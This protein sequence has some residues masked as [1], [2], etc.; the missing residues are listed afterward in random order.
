MTTPR[1][2]GTAEALV[3]AIADRGS[4]GTAKQL[5]E[6]TKGLK[7]Q[8]LTE[9]AICTAVVRSVLQ[10]G[11][12]I[13]AKGGSMDVA[14]ERLKDLMHTLDGAIQDDIIGPRD[15]FDMFEDAFETST[16]EFNKRIFTVL[17]ENTNLWAS[18][19][20]YARGKLP[21][22]RMCN[23]LLKRLSRS[24]DNVYSG[25][26]LTFLAHLYP[27]S[28]KSGLNL[29]GAFSEDAQL[30]TLDG[31]VD[32]GDE[33]MDAGNG[34]AGPSADQNG[35]GA[36]TGEVAAVDST[37]DA[38]GDFHRSFWDLQTYLL[39]PRKVYESEKDW[40]R[41][42]ARIEIVLEAFSTGAA[43]VASGAEVKGEDDEQMDTDAVVSGR[44][45]DGGDL[46]FPKHLTSGS[47]MTMQLKDT[48][49]RR[50]ICVQLLIAFQYL[51]ANVKFKTPEQ[52]LKPQQENF[53]DACIPKV[54]DV[55][56]KTPPDGKRFLR[57]IKYLLANEEFWS[58][59]KN[60]GCP[61]FEREPVTVDASVY[62]KGQEPIWESLA[63][64]MG[65]EDPDKSIDMGDPEL[66]R[67]WN[68]QVDLKDPTRG[69]VPNSSEIFEELVEQEDPDA[70]I[71]E[72]YLVIK[73]PMVRFRALRLLLRNRL[74]LFCRKELFDNGY[75][76]APKEASETRAKVRRTTLKD[77]R[78]MF[79]AMW[80]EENPEEAAAATAA[81]GASGESEMKQSEESEPPSQ[82]VK[83]P[84]DE[85]EADFE[86][87]AD[88]AEP[89]AAAAAAVAAVVESEE[90]SAKRVRTE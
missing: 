11:A 2:D 19:T 21:L 31:D 60:N 40:E 52:H 41:F 79:H 73:N 49:F 16:L 56:A 48:H 63:R 62:F 70:G 6:L 46:Y 53:I 66:T 81:T 88:E 64:T 68:L 47:L 67:L 84:R 26:I 4:L 82:G 50:Q 9:S 8:G 71:E 17:A 18:Q 28:E 43:V 77:A 87:A 65:V 20:Y 12:L 72:T 5:G 44:D 38:V 42:K 27:L 78:A 35:T 22:L 30:V 59:W 89:A 85:A 90:P 15:M 25:R 55:I 32:D 69:H 76:D 13:P 37:G 61:S 58:S 10:S 45:E 80:E 75:R 86:S 39:D 29:T 33:D 34:H 36:E 74:D 7:A 24:L 83:R 54:H 57:S 14:T 3:K 51:K 1:G 23:Q